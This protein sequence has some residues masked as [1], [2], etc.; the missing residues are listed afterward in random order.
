MVDV[1]F[2]LGDL[3]TLYPNTNKEELRKFCSAA[4]PGQ[5]AQSA[6]GYV[7]HTLVTHVEGSVVQYSVC[8]VECVGKCEPC[9]HLISEFL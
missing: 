1:F 5:S 3:T 6:N 8:F 7:R 4:A 9:E 2:D